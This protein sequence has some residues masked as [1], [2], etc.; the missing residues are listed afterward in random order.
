MLQTPQSTSPILSTESRTP[1]MS[2]SQTARSLTIVVSLCT[3]GEI[4]SSVVFSASALDLRVVVGESTPYEM[5]A[6][7]FAEVV[8]D[9]CTWKRQGNGDLLLKLTKATEEE[10]THPFADRAY[11]G[12]VRIDWS[13]W[14]DVNCSDDDD[15]HFDLT[16]LSSASAGDFG[17][18]DKTGFPS[19]SNPEFQDMM[20]GLEKLG[21]DT[22]VKLPDMDAL[23]NMDSDQ[24]QELVKNTS[25]GNTN[26]TDGCSELDLDKMRACLN[27]DVDQ[28]DDRHEHRDKNAGSTEAETADTSSNE[29]RI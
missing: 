29:E 1:L 28:A 13:R 26:T 2:W 24:L 10:W 19:E 6:K 25:V 8:A 7:W 11:K 5:T 20:S 4:Q 3:S 27:V 14:V 22:D 21:R 9:E 16:N 15:D 18:D 17:G 23:K 12:F